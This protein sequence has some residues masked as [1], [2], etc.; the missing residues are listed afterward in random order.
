M[1]PVVAGER[2]KKL[3]IEHGLSRAQ[4]AEQIGVEA[5]AI[6]NY[7]SGIR[8]PRDSIKIRIASV[9]GASVGDIFFTE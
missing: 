3:R 4:L 9:L 8:T 7:E 6:S 1:N 5:S 2:I